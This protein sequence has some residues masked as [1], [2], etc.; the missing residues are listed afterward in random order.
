MLSL[1]R[2]NAYRARFAASHPNWQPSGPL[3]EGLVRR[4]ATPGASWLDLGCGRG[5]IVELLGG[6]VRLCAG[7][8]PDPASLR[9]HRAS[10]VRLSAAQA[11]RLPFASG[12][13]ELVT[14]SWVMEHLPDPSLALAEVARV[15]RPG[16]H[17]VF[18]TPN[19][20]NPI[21]WLNRLA[22]ARLQRAL[23]WRLYQRDEGDTFEVYYRANTPARL[24]RL[25]SRC[26]LQRVE[27]ALVGDP[28]YVAFNDALFDLA[29]WIE[30]ALPP[31]WRVHIVGDYVAA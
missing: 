17:F 4:Y 1:E 23:V 22:P 8:D 28:S 18:L 5:G 29:A 13:F 19:A 24:D 30:P 15:L 16:G 9:E 14:C 26:G 21:T 7:I 27:M 25:L 6:Q 10:L 20:L 2:Q 3:Y 12:S 11:E 31:A